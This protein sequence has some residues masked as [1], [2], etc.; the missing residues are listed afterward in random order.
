MREASALNKEGETQ[1]C[2]TALILKEPNECIL[3][4]GHNGPH[5]SEHT[6]LFEK[7]QLHVVITWEG[8]PRDPNLLSMND[9]MRN[10]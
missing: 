9:I 6:F 10:F 7:D 4:G 2:G 5:R 8:Q 1:R 3:P